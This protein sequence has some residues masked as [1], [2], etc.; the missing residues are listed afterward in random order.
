MVPLASTDTGE[1]AHSIQKGP[2]HWLGIE[3]RDLLAMKVTSLKYCTTAPLRHQINRISRKEN[4]KKT[5]Q[6]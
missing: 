5:K 2:G 3:P 4:K 1:L 6:P